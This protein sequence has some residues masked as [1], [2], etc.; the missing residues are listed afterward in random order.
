MRPEDGVRLPQ[1]QPL[2]GVGHA[3]TPLELAAITQTLL[4]MQPPRRDAPREIGVGG[5]GPDGRAIG[6]GCFVW[7][8]RGLCWRFQ[9]TNVVAL[10]EQGLVDLDDDEVSDLLDGRA[11]P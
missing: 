4:A 11:A 10:P 2:D 9:P 5:R 1:G 7:D 8:P 3:F 6:V